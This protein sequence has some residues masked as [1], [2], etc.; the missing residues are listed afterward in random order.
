M[1]VGCGFRIKPVHGQDYV[2][3]WHYE[4]R[5]GKSR[6]VYDYM[7]P[8]RSSETAHRLSAA[9]EAYYAGAEGELHRALVRQRSAIASLG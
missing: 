6:Q 5:S 4:N 2:Y 8:R 9:V 7:G 3:F 1:Q